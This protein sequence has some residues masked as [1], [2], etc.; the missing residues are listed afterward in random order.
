[1]SFPATFNAPS[2][3]RVA[4]E[5]Q[6]LRSSS[7][8]VRLAARESD[9]HFRFASSLDIGNPPHHHLHLSDSHLKPLGKSEDDDEE[10]FRRIKAKIADVRQRNIRRRR[11]SRKKS[12]RSLN[13]PD[14]NRFISTL[15]RASKRLELDMLNTDAAIHLCNLASEVT[16]H[17][18]DGDP[19]MCA[20]QDILLLVGRSFEAHAHAHAQSR[21][22]MSSSAIV[23]AGGTFKSDREVKM[24]IRRGS[25]SRSIS[26]GNDG[27]SFVEQYRNRWAKAE[28]RR[29]AKPKGD[30][31]L[32]TVLES[33]NTAIK[34]NQAVNLDFDWAS[35]LLGE[36]LMGSERANNNIT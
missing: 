36:E 22:E 11:A 1:M 13:N 31:I 28:R 19:L 32:S 4:S 20:M 14:I 5:W 35:Q 17:V 30:K 8:L 25:K 29:A 21:P 18:D 6:S 10:D 33:M 12:F 16:A 3:N 24:D 2:T 23:E 9:R 34:D 26:N 15:E 7:S 27:E